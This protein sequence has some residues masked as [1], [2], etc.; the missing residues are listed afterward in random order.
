MNQKIKNKDLKTNEPLKSNDDNK[1]DL[2]SKDD[3]PKT[4]DEDQ[5]SDDS[6][7]YEY[8]GDELN[9][10]AFDKV[11]EK[12]IDLFVNIMGV[13]YYSVILF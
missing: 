3:E 1:T 10:L 5:K 13:F 4:I 12:M 6:Q 9:E 2:I 7:L 11:L 8:Q